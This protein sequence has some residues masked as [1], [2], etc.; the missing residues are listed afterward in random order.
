[1]IFHAKAQ[2]ELRKKK[3]NIDDIKKK[4]KERSIFNK[5]TKRKKEWSYPLIV[6]L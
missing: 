1:V 6:L 3:V 5:C 4:K 2:S